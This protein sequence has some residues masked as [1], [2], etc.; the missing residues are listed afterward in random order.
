MNT[1]LINILQSLET[2]DLN[3]IG[4]EGYKIFIKK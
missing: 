4:E 3:F 2:K 1:E